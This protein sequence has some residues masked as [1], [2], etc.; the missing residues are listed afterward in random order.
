MARALLLALTL[1]AA[2]YDWRFR[3]VPNWLVAAGLV[4]GFAWNITQNGVTGPL[5]ALAGAGLALLVYLPL[6]ALRAMG[7]GDAKL[8]AAIGALT[9]P[10]AWWGIF[11]YT[12]L[13][14]AA[15]ALAAIIATGRMRKTLRNLGTITAS[16]LRLRRPWAVNPEIDVRSERALRL[17]HA[18]TIAAATIAYLIF[19]P[20][21]Y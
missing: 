20:L 14:G 1:T 21:R 8:M 19:G 15:A 11:V 10:L 5:M 2:V 6:V 18:V 12:I 16:L 7:A 4:A 13:I 3:V 9:G 17:P